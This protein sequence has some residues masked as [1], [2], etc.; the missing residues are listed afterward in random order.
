MAFPKTPDGSFWI[1]LE[2]QGFGHPIW[3]MDIRF[4][5]LTVNGLRLVVY[6]LTNCGGAEWFLLGT[7]TSS[8]HLFRTDSGRNKSDAGPRRGVTTHPSLVAPL[9]DG[10]D[11]PDRGRGLG[12]GW[13]PSPP[14]IRGDP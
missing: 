13:D 2:V 1:V 3:G 11:P 5:A 14:Q 8:G 7:R 6:R 9:H 4:G 10:G 12:L